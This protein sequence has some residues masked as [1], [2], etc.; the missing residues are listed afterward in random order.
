MAQQRADGG[1]TTPGLCSKCRFSIGDVRR[2]SQLRND[3]QKSRGDKRI[4]LCS[5]TEIDI[6]GTI[7]S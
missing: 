6:E 3:P 2:P 5:M 7:G 1:L 4:R